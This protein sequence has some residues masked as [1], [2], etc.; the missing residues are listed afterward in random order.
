M[1]QQTIDS[2][3]SGYGIPNTETGLANQDK[4]LPLPVTAKKT[5]LRDLQNENRI[6]VPKSLGSS[7]FPKESGP[8]IKAVKASGTKRPAPECLVSAPQHQSPTSNAANGHLVYVRRRPEVELAKSS[9]FDNTNSNAYCPQARK[10]GDH[11]ETPQP[12]S[13]MKEPKICVPEVAPIPRTS[14]MC[15][16]SGKPSV[17]PSLGKS[18]NIVQPT[19]ANYLPIPSST[20]PL[21][22]PKKMNN[23]HWEER[24][25]QL[26]DLLKI[27]DQSNQEDY[28]QML[29]SLSSVELSRHAVELEKRSIQ[30][31]LEEAKEI[32][33]VRL[34]D[35]L[36]KYSEISRAPSAQQG[37]S[38]N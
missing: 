33:R 4:Q 18:S 29:R 36:G 17:P 24:Y 9:I 12:K 19:D 1:V 7:L 21:D 26:Q 5:A 27:L 38:E 15:Y 23:Q 6:A 16:S 31:S 20:P 28:V 22:Y 30:L 34:L 25:C 2:K 14:L 11:N 8:T 37:Q 32:Q 13:Q 10:L 3:F 35:V